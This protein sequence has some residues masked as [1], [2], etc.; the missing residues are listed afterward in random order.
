MI[1]V[2]GKKW[3][4][5]KINQNLVNKLKQ[6][7]NFSDILSRLIISRKF[8]D[9]E[10][11][12][13]NTDLDLNN[14]FL[15]NEDFNQSIK[16][17]VN[18]INNNEK[19][20]ILGDYD[21]DG[22]AATSLFVK[23]LESINHPFFYYIPDREKDGYGATKKLFQKLILKEPKL[24]IMVDCG[25]TS[26]EAID[27][28]NNN[29]IKSLIIDH[30]EI[31]K[32]FPNANSIINPKKN[33]GYKEYDYL[34]ATSLSY[35]F[36]DLLIKEI[37]NK[38]NIKD[39]L[40]YVLL[41]TVCDVMPLRK[42]NRLIALNALKNFDITKNL[43]LSTLF[44]LNN[45][46]NKINI[47]DLGYLI[48]PILNAGGRLGKSEY[49]TELLSSNNDQVIK[50]RS[51]YLIKL[52]KKRKEIET[53]VLN[54]IDFK[55]LE[56][57]NKDVVIY[58]NPN[59]NEGLIG[60]IAA[61]LKDYFNK[62]TIVITTS[63]ELLK[64]SARSVY[65]YNIGRVIKNSLD[66]GIIVNG[67]GHNMAAGFTLN[68]ENLKTFENYILEDFLKSNTVNNNTFSYES[69]ISS[70][71]FNQ[72]FYDNIKKLEPFGTGN[73]VPTFLLRDLRIIKP[74][75]LNNKHISSIL[76]SKTGFSIK[77]ISFNSINT[78]IGEHLMSYKNSLNVI[79][80]INENIWN[81]KKTLQLTIR[82]LFL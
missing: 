46:K 15:N 70:L 69:E 66:K 40:I 32:P 42:L 27:F 6:D 34:C 67:G 43:P 17:V 76:R 41:A 28:L 38:I 18:C 31:N 29:E 65:N 68:R 77:S 16:L 2:S 33:N 55:K 61:R 23:F 49:A 47:N 56:E 63:N 44:D 3:E 35:F 73:P 7:F 74:I 30:H 78:K 71:A 25:S 62:P 50:D 39:Y 21:V 57:E 1:S 64:G 80:Q 36:L 72:D 53:L 79:G 10:I 75:V 4:Q 48:G 37:K 59:I 45:K 26:N 54:E 8:E 52:N 5:K 20:C 58:Y 19:I 22:S 12:T 82:D 60:I 24:I 13:I 14:V 51:I 9:D 11:A 81:N